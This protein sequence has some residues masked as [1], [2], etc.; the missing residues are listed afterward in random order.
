MEPTPTVCQPHSILL[1]D[2]RGDG[3]RRGERADVLGGVVLPVSSLQGS[4][5]AGRAGLKAA[6]TVSDA[7]A[8]LAF[9]NVDVR[10]WCDD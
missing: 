9:Q 4:G 2:G 7:S 8:Q 1:S 3:R 10:S 5:P 6:L